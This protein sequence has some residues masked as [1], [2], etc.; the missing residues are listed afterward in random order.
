MMAEIQDP[1]LNISKRIVEIRTSKRITQAEIS[2]ALKMDNSQYAKLEKRGNKLRLDQLVEI[3]KALSVPLSEIIEIQSPVTVMTMNISENIKKIREQKRI[4]QTELAK[5]LGVEPT[6]YPRLEKRGN[7][8][9]YNYIELFA[10]ALEVSVAE[11][12]GINNPLT[13]P[14]EG[15]NNQ[16]ALKYAMQYLINTNKLEGELLFDKVTIFKTAE[17]FKKLLNT[18]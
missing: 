10:K 13:I 14:N 12:L 16:V 8:L 18:L 7:N 11:L 4:S 5:R 15:K 2:R 9:T 6:N 3:A 17:T 1:F